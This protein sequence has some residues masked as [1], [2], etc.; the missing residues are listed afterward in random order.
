MFTALSV[1]MRGR[2]LA[3]QKRLYHEKLRA[4]LRRLRRDTRHAAIVQREKA[5]ILRLLVR[6]FPSN[7]LHAVILRL[8]A[9][10]ESRHLRKFKRLLCRLSGNATVTIPRR[11]FFVWK[12]WYARNAPR[13]WA[14]LRL[15]HQKD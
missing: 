1:D 4:R 8:L 5:L 13:K 15:K 9:R 12:C 10:N 6:R 2:D 11:R 7:S 14:L 3:G